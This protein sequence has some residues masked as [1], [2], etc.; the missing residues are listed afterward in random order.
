ME[1]LLSENNF[2]F[3][4]DYDITQSLQRVHAL[5]SGMSFARRVCE[6]EVH[7]ALFVLPINLFMSCYESI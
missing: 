2:Y 7:S 5:D 4:T 3:S 1:S 6:R